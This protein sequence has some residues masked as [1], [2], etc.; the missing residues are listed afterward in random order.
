M[1]VRIPPRVPPKRKTTLALVALIALLVALA[2]NPASAEHVT[3][4]SPGL[5]V[6]SHLNL[7]AG[8]GNITDVW[9]HTAA[10]GRS[11]VYVGAYH[12]PTC[13]TE[14][15]GVH[16]VDVSDPA[17]PQRVAFVPSPA[18]ARVSDVMVAHVG[19]RSFSGD[20]MVHGNEPC[21]PSLRPALTGPSTGIAIYDVTDPLRPVQLV[22]S[23]YDFPVHNAFLYQQ[24]DR[25]F[26]LVV[27]D[28]NERDFHIAE[29]T[30]PRAPVEVVSRG[31]ADWFDPNL[32]QMFLGIGPA[33]FLHDVWAQTYPPDHPSASLA[34]KT[35][36][37]LSYWDAGLVLLDIT[38]PANPAFL[39]D[40]DY[41][42]PDPVSGQPPEGNAHV[43]VPTADGS[44]VFLGDE[45][46]SPFGFRFNVDTGPF[47]GSHQAVRAGF[48]TPISQLPD[49]ALNGP[50]VFVGLA[51]PGQPIPPPSTGL[52]SPR[53]ETIAV[54]ERGVC[55]F[56]EK[57]SQVAQAGYGGAVVFA[58]ADA[59][60]QVIV[61]PGDPTLGT[62]PA[63][64]VSRRTAFAIAGLDPMSPSDTPLPVVGTPGQ[65]IT[66]GRGPL[67]GWG[68][69]RILDVS[70][71]VHIVEV[72]HFV[73]E[74]VMA[75][76]PPSG[77][78]TMHNVVVDDRRAYISWYA[79]GI[80]VVDFSD[81]GQPIEVA[82][83][84]DQVAGSDFW[85]VHLL[86]HP[87]GN[88]YV[89][90]S[91]RSTGLWVFLA[92]ESSRE[93][94]AGLAEAPNAAPAPSGT[95]GTPDRCPRGQGP[96]PQMP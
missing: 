5:V 44:L 61:M 20:V 45:D 87:N 40:S 39:G 72:G 59:P 63:V 38:D 91:D 28:V 94:K 95:R 25:A 9:S 27:D 73:T 96:A 81:P 67:D 1:R 12:Q 16:I 41:L 13:S 46:F 33:S 68:Y 4:S 36:A 84:V 78:H 75:D 85:G 48:T 18:G 77:T 55:R 30:N 29:I 62:V 3:S 32:D 93:D 89:L 34:G 65:R 15:T 6:V 26:V 80:R 54:A 86:K 51:C 90:G 74:N 53:E 52:L 31:R 43:A 70:D 79:D 50:T 21:P 57:V 19:T 92:P 88:S 10:S 69:G 22:Q 35:M 58:Q 64:F 23:F 2:G 14:I 56:D 60:D 37:Y 24:G 8:P 71:P 66:A 7:A 17:N 49:G 11:F 76:P 82:H 47:V 83:F 42:D